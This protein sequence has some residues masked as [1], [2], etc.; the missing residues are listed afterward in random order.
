M[1][2]LMMKN[3]Q[4]G[5]IKNKKLYEKFYQE[6]A[7]NEVQ[8][9]IIIRNLIHNRKILNAEKRKENNEIESTLRSNN[10][11][12]TKKQEKS[13]I[14][15]RFFPRTKSGRT[16]IVNPDKISFLRNALKKKLQNNNLLSKTEEEYKHYL[17]TLT[18]LPDLSYNGN[19]YEEEVRQLK[20]MKKKQIIPFTAKFQNAF[21]KG[22][23]LAKSIKLK[24]GGNQTV[25][26][27][28]DRF[29]K[30]DEEMFI[31]K[32]DVNAWVARQEFSSNQVDN[33]FLTDETKKMSK[34]SD[35]VANVR[36]QT[37]LNFRKNIKE[38]LKDDFENYDAKGKIE[39]KEAED[40]VP[41]VDP[42]NPTS[43]RRVRNIVVYKLGKKK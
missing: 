42:T 21:S 22:N 39:K 33:I 4:T 16:K 11:K 15:K 23:Y 7:E 25:N 36:P 32:E 18:D 27:M 37:A 29:F 19:K 17:D 40:T 2:N 14:Y 8:K 38:C 10:A 5:L 26:N 34:K 3:K 24:F 13:S 31:L 43:M 28:V 35:R 41:M 9:K 1:Y 20:A 30:K 6:G 12:A